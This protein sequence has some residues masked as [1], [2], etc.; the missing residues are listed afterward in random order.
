[1]KSKV[2]LINPWIHDFAAYDLWSKPLGL[3]SIASEL[4]RLGL[5][6]HLADCLDIHHPGMTRDSGASPV[7]RAYG[8]GKFW[9]QQIP[10]PS[11]LKG[12]PRSYSRYGITGKLF[13]RDL[14]KMP[15]PD[16]IL[17]TSLMT[18]WYPGVQEAIH[19]AREVFPK[20]PVI[21]GGIYARLCPEHARRH[22]GAD[23][24]ISSGGRDAILALLSVLSELGI[25]FL[26]RARDPE[27]LPYP[28]FDLLRKMDYVCLMTSSGCPYR[29]RYCASPYLNPLSCRQDPARALEEISYWHDIHGIRDFAFYDDA[30]LVDP[31][32]HIIP[33][34]ESVVE[35]GMDVRFHTPN[36]LHVREISGR[37]ADLLKAAGFRTIRL[38]FE[39]ADMAMHDRLDRKVSRGE[40][41]R[42]VNN[43]SNA[44]FAPGQV[45]AYI[46]MGL[47]GQ[48][49]GEVLESIEYAGNTGV[50]PYLAEYSP[51]PHTPMWK[52][53][54]ASSDLDLAG[55]PLYHN[56]TLLPCWGEARRAEVPRL[57]DRVREIRESIN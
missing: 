24:I 31:E 47:P 6:V 40:F 18:Y 21:L 48:S 53:A 23:R 49:V 41:E 3:L 28:S 55:E 8:T 11:P 17:V 15:G 38:G 54:L 16:A 46:L 1:M 36:A 32:G 44:G 57:K 35:K 52:E 37:I 33:L 19:Y 34:L 10:R 9:R 25:T 50:S 22:S 29:C 4:R 39:T 45:G 26:N 27:S 13:K 5:E 20:A 56:N 42:A 43:L 2:L 51:L 7:R 30:L 12:V 14:E